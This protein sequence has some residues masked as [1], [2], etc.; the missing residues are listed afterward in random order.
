MRVL[1]TGGSG[2][3]GQALCQSLTEHGHSVGV[4]SRRP[5]KAIKVLPTAVDVRET[6]AAFTDFSPEAI[7]NL[8]GAPIASGRWTASKKRQLLASR[9]GTTEQLVALAAALETKPQVLISASAV[10]YYG[11]C[12]GEVVTEAT[13]P[14]DGFSHELC[15]RWEEAAK[16]AEEYVDRLCIVRIGLVLDQPGGLLDRMIM[17]FK[18]GLGGRFGSGQQY[19]PW[20]HRQ[21][22]V[23]IFDFLLKNNDLSGIFN[24]SAPNPVTNETFAASLAQALHRPTLLPVPSAVLKMAFGE[25]SE[26]MLEGANMK[27]ERLL[28]A[29]FE[30]S[31]SELDEALEEIVHR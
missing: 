29:G 3:I 30:F 5:S 20:I 9:V 31:Y 24:A 6:V 22:M 23:R 10:G 19:M 27:P 2:F 12:H 8:A 28:Q 21:D 17:P 16:P 7:I 18:L 1:I 11:N 14:G 25:M 4:V 13:G 15:R 26:L